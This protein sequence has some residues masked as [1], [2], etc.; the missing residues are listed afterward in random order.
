MDILQKLKEEID[1]EIDYNQHIISGEWE[2]EDSDMA[3]YNNQ[4]LR[5]IRQRI[6]ELEKEQFGNKQ[7]NS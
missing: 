7:N 2:G 5:F 4:T 3:C 1:M 6:K